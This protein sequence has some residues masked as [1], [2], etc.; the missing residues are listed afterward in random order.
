M[1]EGIEMSKT[2]HVA[3]YTGLTAELSLSWNLKDGG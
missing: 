1:K 3:G 2:E